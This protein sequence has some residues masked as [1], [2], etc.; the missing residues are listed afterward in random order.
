M[1]GTRGYLIRRIGPVE[2]CY[3]YDN[4]GSNILYGLNGSGKSSLIEGLSAALSG[5]VMPRG[6]AATDIEVFSPDVSPAIL[7]NIERLVDN[8]LAEVL[9]Y[10][11]HD[12]E[13][14]WGSSSD[15]D[16][17]SPLSDRIAL[18]VKEWLFGNPVAGASDSETI[19]SEISQ[20][21][22]LLLEPVG[23]RDSHWRVWLAA[24]ITEQTES[25]AFVRRL[26]PALAAVSDVRTGWS[27]FWRIERARELVVQGAQLTDAPLM[28][29][30]GID[31]G[32]IR[33]EE[34][35]ATLLHF[36]LSLLAPEDAEELLMTHLG[37]PDREAAQIVA[38]GFDDGT[39]KLRSQLTLC[40]EKVLSDT[41]S[42]RRDLTVSQADGD[43][44]DL[45]LSDLFDSSMSTPVVP[46]FALGTVSGT[47]S[48]VAVGDF[49]DHFGS[50]RTDVRSVDRHRELLAERDQELRDMGH[51][52]DNDPYDDLTHI[53]DD[54]FDRAKTIASRANEFLDSVMRDP[55]PVKALEPS[56]S[57]WLDAS[58]QVWGGQ[59]SKEGP[60]VPVTALSGAQR[61]WTNIAFGI[62][63]AEP[64]ARTLII[65]EPERSMHRAAIR[66]VAEGLR[67]WSEHDERA[68]WAAT[69]APEFLSQQP[70]TRWHVSLDPFGHTIVNRMEVTTN[71][72]I[73]ETAA[74]LGVA[75][76]DLLQL[77]RT[78]VLVEG[79]HDKVVIE[80][81]LAT[82]L[83]QAHA[84]VL[85]LRGVDNS[86]A[87]VNAE[88]LVDF[89]DAN[90]I[91]V[92]DHISDPEEMATAWN[93]A[94]D[95][96]GKSLQDA[97]RALG[98]RLGNSPLR[99]KEDHALTNLAFGIL[100]SHHANRFQLFG[101]KRPGI[102]QYIP[103]ETLG[104][105]ESIT[106]EDV[107]SAYLDSG[108]PP[109][110][111]LWVR[112]RYGVDISTKLLRRAVRDLDSANLS[113]EFE[114]LSR[115]I[116]S[117]AE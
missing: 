52:S 73:T 48:T 34:F 45:H 25:A 103:A 66:D 59:T 78:F 53:L 51:T 61:R 86:I 98:Q 113:P 109:D 16:E 32:T 41:V 31:T 7:S 67:R 101:L 10:D 1:N 92:F 85:P 69:H 4:A 90:F 75:A 40:H 26:G 100:G 114:A 28:I 91:V 96:H 93:D 102:E 49:D 37:I 94:L 20:A 64:D 105:P 46:L 71:D 39:E 56:A 63:V 99:T 72:S 110:F 43:S 55:I 108:R 115:L 2:T 60:I 68:V 62:A 12:N 9:N 104:F 97:K 76:A 42:V 23:T 65:D 38:S 74:R 13:F 77:I 112:S 50:A 14:A 22:R 116:L 3:L 29:R 18:L 24:D 87:N 33:A 80:S 83:E 35:H 89:T 111:K 117:D 79:E 19:A 107:E 57:D 17:N 36:I 106:W 27:V 30:Y 81:I 70:S 95:A 15:V 6:S 47:T 5:K 8:R 54:S 84:Y 21:G 58:W 44:E 11:D 88:V 82:E